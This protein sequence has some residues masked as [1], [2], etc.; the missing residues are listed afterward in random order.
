MFTFGRQ[1]VDR[2]SAMN[3][4]ALRFHALKFMQVLDTCIKSLEDNTVDLLQILKNI[5]ILCRD[6]LYNKHIFNYR[7]HA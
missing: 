1:S 4:S 6:F 5:G 3:D 2:D 7:S